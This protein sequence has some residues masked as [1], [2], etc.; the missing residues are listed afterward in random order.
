MAKSIKFT[1]G[2]VRLSYAHLDTPTKDAQGNE[3]YSAQ[4]IF[5]KSDKKTLNRINDAI[6]QLKENPEVKAQFNNKFKDARLPIRD[7]DEDEADFVTA[8]P[9]VYGGQYFVGAKANKS[10]RPSYYHRDK[11][12]MDDFEV[13]DELYSGCYAQV[14]ANV[15]SY[16]AQGNKGFG[17]GLLAVRKIRDGEKLGGTFVSESDFED[18]D[19]DDDES[20]FD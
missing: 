6:K 7:G 13:S 9:G 2:V 15:Y 8:Q 5:D 14:V 10:Y 19:F 1:T 4:L 18:V 16:S 11:T 12:P 17:I 3:I 20:V